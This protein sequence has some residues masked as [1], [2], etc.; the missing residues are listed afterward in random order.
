M[1]KK[2]PPSPFGTKTSYEKWLEAEGLDVITGYHLEDVY[3][4]PLKPWERKGGLGAIIN[5]EGGGQTNDAYICEIPPGK[6]LKPQRHLFEELIFILKG[7]GTTALWYEGG[8]KRVIE[9][10]EGS[11]FSPPLNPLPP[12]EGKVFVS[13]PTRGGEE[14]CGSSSYCLLP[15]ACSQKFPA[16]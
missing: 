16:P 9:W 10:Q 13:P 15:L 8:P 12:G 1:E 2:L 5:L 11:L 6:G 3:S 7:R 4:V 14:D